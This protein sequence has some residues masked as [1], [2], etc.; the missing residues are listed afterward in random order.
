MP[1]QELTRACPAQS[2]RAAAR[3]AIMTVGRWV[4]ADGM[5]GITD[6]STTRRLVMPWTRQAASTTAPAE[7]SIPIAQVPT[8]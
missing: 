4:F 7:G 1:I 8:G 3:S 6:A 2:L 5:S